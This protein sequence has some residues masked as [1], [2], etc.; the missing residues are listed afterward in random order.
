MENEYEYDVLSMPASSEEIA[1]RIAIETLEY[2]G[3]QDIHISKVE[4][5]GDKN[6]FNVEVY[7]KKETKENTEEKTLK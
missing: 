5:N 6:S 1:K 3:K 7:Y 2:L 4:Q